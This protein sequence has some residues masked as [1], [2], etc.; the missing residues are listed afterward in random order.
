MTQ[1]RAKPESSAPGKHAPDH[2]PQFERLRSLV[3]RD[4]GLK[5][6]LDFAKAGADVNTEGDRSS[7]RRIRRPY[8]SAPTLPERARH[9]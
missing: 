1:Q 6:A 9:K 3:E 4:P 5:D 2:G 7:P 8:V